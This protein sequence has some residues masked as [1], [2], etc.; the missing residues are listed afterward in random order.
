ME[1]DKTEKNAIAYF[2]NC[3]FEQLKDLFKVKGG[4]TKELVRKSLS[5]SKK[6]IIDIAGFCPPTHSGNLIIVSLTN[7]RRISFC[8]EGKQ[9]IMRKIPL[10][11][12]PETPLEAATNSIAS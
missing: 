9:A 7:K 4:L 2:F 5:A 10:F 1:F 11:L 8:V 6:E 12:P 3:P